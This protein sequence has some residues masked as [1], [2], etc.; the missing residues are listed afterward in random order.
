MLVSKQFACELQSS[1]SQCGWFTNLHGC[2]DSNH[3]LFVMSLYRPGADETWT[4][5]RSHLENHSMCKGILGLISWRNLYCLQ[6]SFF[7]QSRKGFSTSSFR[8]LWCRKGSPTGHH[9]KWF[10]FIFL[11]SAKFIIWSPREGARSSS[12]SA[13]LS[14]PATPSSTPGTSYQICLQVKDKLHEEEKLHS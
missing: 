2:L 1:I 6:T 10:R 12:P 3:P 8:R 13:T 7:L 4:G 11:C 5:K 9:G 14:T